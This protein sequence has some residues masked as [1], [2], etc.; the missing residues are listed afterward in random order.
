MLVAADYTKD[1]ATFDKT[2]AKDEKTFKPMGR[3][4][5]EYA[6]RKKKDAFNGEDAKGKGK[7]KEINAKQQWENCEVNDEG[8]TVFEAYQVR[9][10]YPSRSL[11]LYKVVADQMP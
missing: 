3:K 5:G 9:S 4:I 1:K 10:H 2:V 8:A 6:R 11:S 7:A